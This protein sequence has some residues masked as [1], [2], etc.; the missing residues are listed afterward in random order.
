VTYLVDHPVDYRGAFARLRRDLRMLYFSAFQSHLWNLMLSRWIERITRP[1]QRV[2]VEFRLATMPIHHGLDPDQ[3]ESLATLRIALPSSRNPLPDGPLGETA[4]EV[5]GEFGL[6]WEDLRVKALK[7]VFFSKGARPALFFAGGL[8]HDV[9]NDE[10][11]PG[12][13][14][15]RL[16]FDLPKGAYATLVVKRVTDAA[17]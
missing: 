10:F 4:V 13:K 12:R 3:A 14:A 5:L 7:D 15:L 17:G 9:A 6:A 2:P 11:H 1:D 16:M 8:R